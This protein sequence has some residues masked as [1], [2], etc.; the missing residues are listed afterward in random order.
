[1]NWWAGRNA[2]QLNLKASADITCVI[3]GDP[4]VKPCLNY[5]TPAGLV[6]RTFMQYSITFCSRPEAA[7]DIVSSAFMRH[8]VAHKIA[9]LG[10]PWLISSREMRPQS[11]HFIR[12]FR[13]KCW[14][15]LAN[16]VTSG[17]AVDEVGIDVRVKC[18]DSTSNCSWVTRAAH[19][20]TDE[21]QPTEIV[22]IGG[23]SIEAFRLKMQPATDKGI[24]I[25]LCM[26]TDNWLMIWRDTDSRI[27][28][29]NN[30]WLRYYS[31]CSAIDRNNAQA[32]AV[33]E[34]RH[35]TTEFITVGQFYRSMKR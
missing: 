5:S 31:G 8:S 29:G 19:F 7:I 28:T 1:M 2:A 9:K 21:R 33:Q 25:Y 26:H 24:L 22:T 12:L 18:G 11:R 13:D 35:Q 6:S 14:P 3:S 17:A 32:E 20:V 16:D 30:D 10:D 15:K 23:N 4:G 34:I 27:S